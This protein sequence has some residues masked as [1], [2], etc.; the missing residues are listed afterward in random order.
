MSHTDVF[1]VYDPAT[2][3]PVVARYL[4]ARADDERRQSVV[5]AFTADAR[6][7][8][9]G[10]D[11]HGRDGIRAWLDKTGSEYTYTTA[12]TGQRQDGPHQWTVLVHLEGDFP[13]GVVDLRYRFSLDQDRISRLII[14]P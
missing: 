6:V 2:V 1:D 7:T 9:E 3:P 10:I 8:D 4:S 13:G 11:Y 5:E 12:P 14:A